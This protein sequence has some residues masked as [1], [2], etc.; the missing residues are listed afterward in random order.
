MDTPKI[1]NLAPEL[2]RYCKELEKDIHRGGTAW[3]QRADGSICEELFK[4]DRARQLLKSR[5][6]RIKIDTF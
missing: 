2:E 6:K 5:V 4:E 1:I 3:Y